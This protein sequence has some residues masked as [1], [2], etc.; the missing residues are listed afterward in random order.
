[1][2]MGTCCK[3]LTVLSDVTPKHFTPTQRLLLNVLADGRPHSRAEL[4]GCFDELAEV[5]RVRNTI[6]LM[7]AKLRPEG[8]DIVCELRSRQIWYRHVRLLKPYV[9]TGNNIKAS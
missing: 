8:E 6:S 4:H 7:R 9:A 1:M 5:K 3:G 2:W